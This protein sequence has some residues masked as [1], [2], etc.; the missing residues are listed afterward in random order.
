LIRL[1]I[2]CHRAQAE[3]VL[4][5]LVGIA[6]DGVEEQAGED[7]VEYSI[8]GAPGELPEIGEVHAV[9]DGGLVEVQ[10]TEVPDDWASRWRDFHRP[11]TVESGS[12][13]DVLWVGAPWHERPGGPL[14]EITIDPGRA[15]GTGAHPTTRL[16]LGLM[17]D[18]RERGLATGGLSDV[19]TGS[20]V[21][22]IA[23]LLLG[24]DPVSGLDHEAASIES[25]IA[26]AR[27]NG[28]SGQ[29]VRKDLREGFDA[30]HQTVSANLTAPLLTELAAGLPES[31]L[32]L[33]IVCS[34]LLDEES[35]KVIESFAGLGYGLASKGSLDGWTGL[36]LEL[37][38][39]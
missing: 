15:F 27:A 10:A 13:Q 16:C 28:V 11:V 26:N 38:R 5:E 31:N 14:A 32:P 19:G 7:W 22:A 33:R 36:L 6:P 2:R 24:W 17:L 39:D 29:F 9:C 23:G 30:I 18:L 8:Y 1:S 3:F 37:E 20:G 12:G 34:G 25:A 21:L 4:A 35:E